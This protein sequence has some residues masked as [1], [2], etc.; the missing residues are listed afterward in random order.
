MAEAR[1]LAPAD[2]STSGRFK[3]GGWF[4]V[5]IPGVIWGSSFLYV[6]EALKIVGPYGIAF[7]QIAIGFLT[8][9]FFREARR[10]VASSAWVG[11]AGLG[12]I[13]FALRFSLFC[14]AQQLRVSSALTGMLNGSAPLFVVL[15]AAILAKQLPAARIMWGIF[16]GMVGTVLV[17]LPS[18]REGRDTAV[19]ILFVLLACFFHGAALSIARPLQQR[20][21]ALPVVWRALGIATLFTS[22]LGITDL[23]RARW[24]VVPAACLVALG[25]LNTGI[26][27]AL[28][29]IATGRVGVTRASAATFFV[30]PVALMLGVLVRHERVAWLSVAG[31]LVCLMGAWMIRP[32]T[33]RSQAVSETVSARSY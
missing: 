19:G 26:A 9:S 18:Y 30:P 16:V 29:T 22:V 23:S 8:L 13:W 15:V 25:A 14:F 10:P 4:L 27:F 2:E 21:G 33:L 7:S 6:A 31:A 5:V 11:I 17:A 24:E 20:Y 1:N 28:L 12:L 32:R 3:T